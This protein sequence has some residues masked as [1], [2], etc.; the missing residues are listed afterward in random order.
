MS[1]ESSGA[2]RAAIW[3]DLECGGYAA[4]L[5]LW[6]ELAGDVAQGESARVLDLG[7]G[8]GRVSLHLA[9]LGHSVTALDVDPELLAVT[10]QRARSGGVALRPVEADA[11]SFELGAS[12]DLVLAAMQMM[13]LFGSAAERA[14]LVRHAGDHLRHGGVF[15]AALADIEGEAIDGDYVPPLPEMLELGGWVYA[16]HATGIRTV[17]GGDAIVLERVR[18]VVSPEGALE[19]SLDRIRLELLE[20][21]TLEREIE[22]TGLSIEPRRIIPATDD[23]MGSTVVIGSKA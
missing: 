4:D 17:D 21:A 16:S 23:H 19:E 22:Q 12:F 1:V 10:V 14:S 8:T 5:E 18:R 11:R 7:C 20:P 6:E 15:A 13:Q 9:A 3:H 2:A